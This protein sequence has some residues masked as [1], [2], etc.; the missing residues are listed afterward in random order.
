[1]IISVGKRNNWTLYVDVRATTSQ[2]GFGVRFAKPAKPAAEPATAKPAYH[3]H[4]A[5]A[6]YLT[7]TMNLSFMH[8]WIIDE[9]PTPKSRSLR[10]S[11]TLPLHARIQ[12]R[13][14]AT[15]DQ[16]MA[17]TQPPISGPCRMD[18]LNVLST[19][20]IDAIV[21]GATNYNTAPSVYWTPNAITYIRPNVCTC[22]TEICLDL[23]Q[24]P[25]KLKAVTVRPELT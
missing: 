10:S 22:A 15:V 24:Y 9:E 5:L 21:V 2:I 16:Q 11:L 4:S 12:S 13:T 17:P 20:L 25:A 3:E 8:A 7:N 1:M 14:S 6:C 23:R 18:G 19:W